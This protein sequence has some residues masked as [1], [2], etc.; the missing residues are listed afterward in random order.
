M[1]LHSSWTHGGSGIPGS[2]ANEC[3]C[4]RPRQPAVP[5]G[6][7]TPAPPGALKCHPGFHASQA[8]SPHHPCLRP[9][10]T[11]LLVAVIVKP[12]CADRVFQS[13]QAEQ[14]FCKLCGGP[15]LSEGSRD[16]TD[17]A[18]TTPAVSPRTC[19][20]HPV[21]L[22]GVA[23]RG[24]AWHGLQ[25]AELPSNPNLSARRGRLSLT[26]FTYRRAG[27]KRDGERTNT[28]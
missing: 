14:N 7:C 23:L 3:H 24:A 12:P 26:Y 21:P 27:T 5:Q 25:R 20:G 2:R 17:Q 4:L 19:Q 8:C 1:C 15:G 22:L 6:S 13:L 16:S 10:R 18:L 11:L 9:P 28:E